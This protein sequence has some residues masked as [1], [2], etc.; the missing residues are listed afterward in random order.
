MQHSE[1]A[2]KSWELRK[3]MARV[4]GTMNLQQR[5]NLLVMVHPGSQARSNLGYADISHPAFLFPGDLFPGSEVTQIRKKL[6]GST[7]SYV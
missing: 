2:I 3:D 6:L 4:P 5:I 1:S 7:G